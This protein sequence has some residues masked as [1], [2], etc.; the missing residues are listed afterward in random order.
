MRKSQNETITALEL[1]EFKRLYDIGASNDEEAVTLIIDRLSD[2][3]CRRLFTAMTEEKISYAEAS[4][5]FGLACLQ[6]YTD[7]VTVLT[8]YELDREVEVCDGEIDD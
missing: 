6:N 3:I 8:G 1:D 7:K 2:R 4:H 5:R